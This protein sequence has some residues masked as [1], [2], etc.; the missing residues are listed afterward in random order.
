VHADAAIPIRIFL[1]DFES[2]IRAAVIHNEILP[3]GISLGEDALD[4][5]PEI[6]FSVEDGSQNHH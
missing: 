3:V 2:A 5:L 4:T 6:L 1:S